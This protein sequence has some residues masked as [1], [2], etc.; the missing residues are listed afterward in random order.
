MRQL[1]AE[2]AGPVEVYGVD[3]AL[4]LSVV[5]SQAV[6][7]ELTSDS[8]LLVQPDEG[9]GG[10]LLSYAFDGDAWTWLPTGRNPLLAG[11]AGRAALVTWTGSP[12]SDD[13]L[14]RHFAVLE[15]G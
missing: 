4:Q 7:L 5:D 1:C 13:L 8:L 14:S 6:W 9:G 3:G 10:R 15:F 11:V 12:T 2:E